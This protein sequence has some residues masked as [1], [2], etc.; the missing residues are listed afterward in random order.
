P[1]L[2]DANGPGITLIFSAERLA[3]FRALGTTCIPPALSIHLIFRGMKSDDKAR[4]I[5]NCNLASGCSRRRG[6]PSSPARSL[7]F[8][9]VETRVDAQER[10]SDHPDRQHVCRTDAILRAL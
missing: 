10:R 2:P 3:G 4:E 6:E 1:H 7:R 8:S 5:S 9:N